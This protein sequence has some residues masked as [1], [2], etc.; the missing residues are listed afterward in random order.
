MPVLLLSYFSMVYSV[1]GTAGHSLVV[2]AL[3]GMLPDCRRSVV[4]PGRQSIGGS[5]G[6]R[7]WRWI[8]CTQ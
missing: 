7:L 4:L 5:V 8:G 2:V 6:P 3:E 1:D